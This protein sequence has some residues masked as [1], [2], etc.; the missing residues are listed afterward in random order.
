MVL[1][2]TQETGKSELEI[3][4]EKN[5]YVK[6]GLT[7]EEMEEAS[8]LIENPQYSNENCWVCEMVERKKSDPRIDKAIYDI[9]MCQ[10]H[11]RYA[12]STRK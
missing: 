5:A 1:E 10:G 12:L 4:L 9:G 7:P 11:A 3:L 2:V 8:K 6:E